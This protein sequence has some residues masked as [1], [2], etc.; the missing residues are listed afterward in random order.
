MGLLGSLDPSTVYIMY[1][2]KAK[3]LYAVKAYG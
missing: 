2:D 1:T 3:G